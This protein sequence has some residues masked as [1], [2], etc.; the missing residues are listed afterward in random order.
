M[1]EDSY[2]RRPAY[3]PIPEGARALGMLVMM[4]DDDEWGLFATSL[5]NTVRLAAFALRKYE[6]ASVRK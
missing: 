1:E 5:S 3:E 4:L 2:M 6:I